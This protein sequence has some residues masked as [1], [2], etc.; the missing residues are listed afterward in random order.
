MHDLKDIEDIEETIRLEEE[1]TEAMRKSEVTTDV[2]AAV[3][4]VL[5]ESRVVVPNILL[6]A[7]ILYALDGKYVLDLNTAEKEQASLGL[8]AGEYY[9]YAIKTDATPE[10]AVTWLKDRA[11]Q[12][13]KDI[14][15]DITVVDWMHKLYRVRA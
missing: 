4:N 10:Q 6:A 5:M 7:A 9:E 13:K 14:E 15:E 8:S 3:V 12:L 11:N 2:P 1:L